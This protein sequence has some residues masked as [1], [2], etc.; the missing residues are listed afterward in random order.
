[1]DIVVNMDPP[2][3]YQ[4]F[5]FKYFDKSGVEVGGY[6]V[7]GVGYSTAKGQVEHV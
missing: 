5:V 2:Q 1:M 6:T 7:M 4:I 3:T